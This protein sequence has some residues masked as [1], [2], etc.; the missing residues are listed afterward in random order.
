MFLT[1]RLLGFISTA[2]FLKVTQTTPPLISF[3]TCPH[4]P[5]STTTMALTSSVV[6]Y[7]A[8]LSLL[9]SCVPGAYWLFE[10]IMLLRRGKTNRPDQL[11]HPG[12]DVLPTNS[13]HSSSAVLLEEYPPPSSN[14]LL[15]MV[16]SGAPHVSAAPQR[17]L[18]YSRHS[19]ESE[20]QAMWLDTNNLVPNMQG[21]VR[22]RT[23]QYWYIDT[24]S[25]PPQERRFSQ[26][27]NNQYRA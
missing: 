24:M 8:L 4:F 20:G 27:I 10:K 19:P 6:P 11:E 3:L 26:G 1:H 18:T 25:R 15:R 22:I 12:W 2:E 17:L 14:L 23:E 13:R 7:L 16:N 21:Q 9:V 5:T